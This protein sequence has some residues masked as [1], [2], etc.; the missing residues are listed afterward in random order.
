MFTPWQKR[1]CGTGVFLAAL[2]I[3]TVL[4]WRGGARPAVSRIPVQEKTLPVATPDKAGPTAA[5]AP[6]ELPPPD[7]VVMGVTNTP[8]GDAIKSLVRQWAALH[9][10]KAAAWVRSLPDGDVKSGL[11]EDV[12][13]VWSETD[14]V[15]A[16]EWAKGLPPDD[17]RQ[18]AVLAAGYEAARANPTNAVMAAL[19]AESGPAR[20]QLMLHAV[21]EWSA[22]DPMA[23][24]HWVE[25]VRE[26]GLRDELFA[27]LATAWAQQD[28]EAAA[29]L[30]SKVIRQDAVHRRAVVAVVQRWAQSDPIAARAWVDRLADPVL[31]SNCWD[32]VGSR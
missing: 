17:G 21:K 10:E 23:A 19:T 31:Q 20:N 25:T 2:L 14:S 29:L 26:G 27:D 24:L 4:L 8:D 12:A 15:A 28:G 32:A 7:R 18:I 16:L 13:I 30:A 3:A 22:A 11:L 5:A 6:M 9:P 1:V